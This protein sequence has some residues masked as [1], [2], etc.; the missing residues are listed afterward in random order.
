MMSL[1]IKINGLA[2]HVI[3]P[4]AD[5]RHSGNEHLVEKIF[6]P[7]WRNGRVMYG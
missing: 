6:Y 4:V 3:L 7:Y 1:S 2:K 5:A